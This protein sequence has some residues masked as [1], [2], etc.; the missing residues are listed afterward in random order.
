MTTALEEIWGDEWI[1]ASASHAFQV[2]SFAVVNFAQDTKHGD[3]ES[4]STQYRAKSSTKAPHHY[5]T[6]QYRGVMI[7]IYALITC[8]K[9][10]TIASTCD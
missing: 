7:M 3:A 6:G 8:G 9:L 10:I 1:A 4:E 2:T 5:P